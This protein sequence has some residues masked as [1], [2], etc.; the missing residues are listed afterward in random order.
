MTF[1]ERFL[2]TVSFG[3]PDRLPYWEPLGY[4]EATLRRWVREGLPEDMR[5]EQFLSLDRTDAVPVC[6]GP[7]PPHRPGELPIARPGDFRGVAA[8]YSCYSPARYP[9]HWEDCKRCWAGR[10]YPLRIEL[11]GPLTWLARWLGRRAAEVVARERGLADE[12]L[13]FL[14][15]YLTLT[16]ERAAGEVDVD[17]VVIREWPARPWRPGLSEPHV[18]EAMMGHY[19]TLCSFFR[20]HGVGVI[21]LSTPDNI[22]HL[23]PELVAAGVSG[24]MPCRAGAGMD[25]LALAEEH[26]QLLIVGGLDVR[27]LAR[28]RR[29]ADRAAR[30][31]VRAAAERGGWIPCLDEPIPATV[32]LRN[33]EQHWHTARELLAARQEEEGSQG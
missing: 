21:V 3:S 20:G 16:L 7:M 28:Q 12:A 13:D 22:P 19:E 32:P 18:A 14:L 11:D 29:H 31:K 27:Q 24:I 2:A 1:R 6:L 30:I 8:H 4:E 23:V 9:Q 5:I 25:V 17:Y 15:T 26:P 10:D 33:Y